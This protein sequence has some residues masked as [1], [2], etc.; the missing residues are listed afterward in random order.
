MLTWWFLSTNH[1]APEGN[2]ASVSYRPSIFLNLL[3]SAFILEIRAPVPIV[4][5]LVGSLTANA[6]SCC[7]RCCH[8]CSRKASQSRLSISKARLERWRLLD[9]E[10]GLRVWLYS[11]Q[12]PC[13]VHDTD[14]AFLVKAKAGPQ[15]Q[16]RAHVSKSGSGKTDLGVVSRPLR[17]IPEDV[18]KA[19]VVSIFN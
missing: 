15:D 6:N 14:E 12:N 17:C 5:L 10:W 4:L 7:C 2:R 8:S 16:F 11:M 3:F 9:E 1:R 19:N 18:S 13:C